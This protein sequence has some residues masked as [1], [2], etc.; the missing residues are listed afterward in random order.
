MAQ[1]QWLPE[2]I[3]LTRHQQKLVAAA[4]EIQTVRPNAIDFLQQTMAPIEQDAPAEDAQSRLP[5]SPRPIKY[6]PAKVAA[7]KSR[8]NTETRSVGP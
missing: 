3:G 2:V 6:D 5:Q 8:G 1:G 7:A 4:G